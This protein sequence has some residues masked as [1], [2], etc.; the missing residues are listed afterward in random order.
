MHKQGDTKDMQND[1]RYENI[2]LEIDNFFK[3][4]IEKAKKFG[5]TKIVL[6]VGIGF[7]K[8]LE[9]NLL[10]IKH[11]THFLHF[12]YELSYRC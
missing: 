3:A 9:H 4:R 8:T 11:H 1:P 2:I 10:L 12:G 6:D 7:G 5:I